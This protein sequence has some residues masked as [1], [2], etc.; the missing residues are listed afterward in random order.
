M[1]EPNDATGVTLPDGGANACASADAWN[2]V[3]DANGTHTLKLTSEAHTGLKI[4]SSQI[5]RGGIRLLR[6]GGGHRR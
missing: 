1:L 5:A 2:R 4:P 3:V 6:P